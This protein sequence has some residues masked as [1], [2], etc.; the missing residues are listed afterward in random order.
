MIILMWFKFWVLSK[1]RSWYSFIVCISC[2]FRAITCAKSYESLSMSS[3]ASS[4][5]SSSLRAF[6]IYNFVY[7][8]V[9]SRSRRYYV[10][11]RFILVSA[12]SK[13]SICLACFSF[14]SSL[15]SRSLAIPF[16]LISNSFY[17]LSTSAIFLSNSAYFYANSFPLVASFF[18]KP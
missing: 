15:N 1:L 14:V 17:S 3:L 9:W 11:N 7:S 16:F 13:S 10:I 12:S 5:R 6:S 18:E 2:S 4:S 8:S